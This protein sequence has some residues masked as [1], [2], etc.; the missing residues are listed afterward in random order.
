[1]RADAAGCRDAFQGGGS[2]RVEMT[3]AA[4]SLCTQLWAHC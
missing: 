1:M 4:L 3:A 2:K